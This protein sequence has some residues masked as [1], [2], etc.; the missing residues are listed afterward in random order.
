MILKLYLISKLIQ[1][2]PGQSTDKLVFGIEVVQI[3]L[4]IPL[5][6]VISIDQRIDTETTSLVNNVEKTIYH[7]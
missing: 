4:P 6:Y 1:Q 3:K 5:S 2:V 7:F